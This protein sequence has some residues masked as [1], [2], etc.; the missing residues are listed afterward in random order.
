[1]PKLVSEIRITLRIT[2]TYFSNQ[3]KMESLNQEPSPENVLKHQKLNQTNQK[4]EE[5]LTDEIEKIKLKLPK[6]PRVIIVTFQ[7]KED[8][9]FTKI[10]NVENPKVDLKYCE[11]GQTNF[12]AYIKTGLTH[13]D[14]SQVTIEI[15][16]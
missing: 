11:I 7:Q 4:I 5:K 8:K 14:F 9:K 16:R 13:G 15:L 12:F 10:V 2:A 6:N 3:L 1:M